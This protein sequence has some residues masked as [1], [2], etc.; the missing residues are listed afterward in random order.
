MVLKNLAEI[1]LLRCYQDLQRSSLLSI[2]TNPNGL[3]RNT[4]AWCVYVYNVANHHH[5]QRQTDI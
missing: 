3:L 2:L 1:F 5:R 4:L